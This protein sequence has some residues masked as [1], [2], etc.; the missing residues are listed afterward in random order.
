MTLLRNPEATPNR[1]VGAWR[2]LDE[3]DDAELELLVKQALMP[4]SQLPD[5]KSDPRGTLQKNLD[6]AVD[7]GLFMRED[8]RIA[9]AS[10]IDISPASKDADKH[11]FVLER[12]LID[13]E[14]GDPGFARAVAWFLTQDLL[15]E[16]WTSD[17]LPLAIDRSGWKEKTGLTSDTRFTVFRVW[18]Q[19]FGF[20]S[21]YELNGK[22]VIT[23]DPTD[24]IA[25]HL[26]KIVEEKERKVSLL[27]VIGSLSNRC[28]VFEGGVYRQEAESLLNRGRPKR[29]LS[30]S[31][32]FALLRLRDQGK[33]ELVQESDAPNAMVLQSGDR[34]PRFSHLVHH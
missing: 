9:V 5:R 26:P 17:S 33:I 22:S 4:E 15:Q 14:Q 2:Y 12:L 28:P 27:Q 10:D 19:Y 24:F 32:S 7:I 34:S 3:K 29:H 31:T 16:P 1:L 20:A 11:R 25:R 30:E 23:P 18:T 8:N 13:D 21:V 6:V